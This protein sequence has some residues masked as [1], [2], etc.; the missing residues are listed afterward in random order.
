MPIHRKTLT[1]LILTMICTLIANGCG[2]FDVESIWRDRDVVVDGVETDDE[3]KDANYFL[4]DY[5]AT[6]GLMNDE[7]YLYIRLSSSDRAIHGQIFGSGLTIWLNEGN[8]DKIYGIKYPLG[9]MGGM[10]PGHMQHKPA[11]TPSA[12]EYDERMNSMVENAKSAVN[13]IGPVENTSITVSNAEIETLGMSLQIGYDKGNIFY[14]IKIPLY[15][16][17]Q[18][19]YGICTH[20]VDAV[21]VGIE[22]EAS[23]RPQSRGGGRGGGGGGMGRGRSSGMGGRPSGGGRGPG[24]EGM[25][26]PSSGEP[27][28]LWLKVTLSQQ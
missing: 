7:Q 3:W 24:G 16:N 27:L 21:G 25:S 4:E 17:E 9:M 13:I 2:M 18:S 12:S 6:I 11:E 22:S 23:V 10:S 28:E 5:N 14:E 8:K 15:R 19:P 26:S 1:I 20:A